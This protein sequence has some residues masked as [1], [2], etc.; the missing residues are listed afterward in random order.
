MSAPS[1]RPWTARE[2]EKALASYDALRSRASGRACTAADLGWAL[3]VRRGMSKWISSYQELVPEPAPQQTHK[4]EDNS[5]TVLPHLHAEVAQ[6]LA[7]MAL[8]ASDSGPGGVI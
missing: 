2:G 5:P 4:V 6:L 8:A 3:L 7:G 1:T